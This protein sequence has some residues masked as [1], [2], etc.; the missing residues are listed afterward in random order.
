[1]HPVSCMIY[2]FHMSFFFFISGYI[3]QKTHSI[4]DKGW[5]YFI[6]KKAT[7]L[8]IPYIFWLL[9]A[10]LFL[11][12]LYPTTFLSFIEL[13][14]FFP[15]QHIWFLPTLFIFMLLFLIG[16]KIIGNR[17]EGNIKYELFL[18]ILSICI[19]CISG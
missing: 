18:S 1:M 14:K 7:S 17:T 11:Q 13:F 15:N 4:D 8:L 5:Q 10:P 19:W 6:S 16:Y 2:S 9:I 12:N 3:N